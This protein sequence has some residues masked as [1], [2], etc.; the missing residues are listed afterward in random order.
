MAGIATF[1]ATTAFPHRYERVFSVLSGKA[2]AQKKGGWLTRH[3][4]VS[5]RK[6]LPAE[7]EYGGNG[8]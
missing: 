3:E 2:S 5:F 6:K 1:S 8:I 4:V 7:H